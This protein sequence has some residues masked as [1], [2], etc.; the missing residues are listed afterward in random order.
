MKTVLKEEDKR[1]EQQNYSDVPQIT[2]PDV[3]LSPHH[4]FSEYL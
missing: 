1:E 3:S 2:E 4:T